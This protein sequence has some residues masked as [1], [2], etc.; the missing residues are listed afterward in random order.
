[1]P[2]RAQALRRV[3]RLEL[4]RACLFILRRDEA[5]PEDFFAGCDDGEQDEGM[6]EA[7][8][9]ARALLDVVTSAKAAVAYTPP[10]PEP[11]AAPEPAPAAAQPAAETPAAPVEPAA[12][13]KAGGVNSLS[14]LFQRAQRS[15]TRWPPHPPN[16]MRTSPRPCSLRCPCA[17]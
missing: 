10:A 1:M 11:T 13:K 12:A 5:L 14:Y 15:L 6:A 9:T 3:Q 8:E 16:L 7:E 4:K 2:G 17:S